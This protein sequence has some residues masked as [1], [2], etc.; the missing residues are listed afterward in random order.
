MQ[1]NAPLIIRLPESFLVLMKISPRKRLFIASLLSFSVNV[2]RR[3]DHIPLFNFNFQL[4]MC[5]FHLR[6]LTFTHVCRNFV[7]VDID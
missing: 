1:K 5:L 2:L 3:F 6:S 4:D 7:D